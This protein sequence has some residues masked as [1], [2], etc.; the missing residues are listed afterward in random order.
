MIGGDAVE[1]D[2]DEEQ[3]D[4]MQE[5]GVEVEPA[6]DQDMEEEFDIDEQD[7][8]E[9][10]E[11]E[12]EA[13]GVD[14]EEEEGQDEENLEQVVEDC[15]DPDAEICQTDAWSVIS[16]YFIEKG[17]VLQQLE[18]FNEFI[19]NKIQEI[20]E[21]N[22]E[23]NITPES[24]KNPGEED[25]HE[26]M[27]YR[28]KFKQIY[29]SKPSIHEVD[30]EQIAL[31]P[32]E[33]R[34]RNLT[35]AAQL[36]V[37]IEKKQV[38]RTID[39]EYELNKEL[40]PQMVFGKVPIM[41]R[42]TFCSLHGHDDK[43]LAQLGECPYDQGGYFVINGSEKVIIAQERMAHNHVYV[44]KRKQP[45]KYAFTVE[46]KSVLEN[47]TRNATGFM[48]AMYSK[49]GVRSGTGGVIRVQLPYIKS[50]IPIMI[51][52]R[53]LGYV[54]TCLHVETRDYDSL[55]GSWKQLVRFLQIYQIR[56]VLMCIRLRQD[57][58]LW[59]IVQLCE[60]L[61]QEML[62]DYNGLRKYITVATCRVIE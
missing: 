40:L 36:C 11:M 42:S 9:E 27:E 30:G 20:V 25:L 6:F 17:L 29:I 59:N 35:Y 58:Y 52:F 37:D 47:S 26:K 55:S 22:G 39:S 45:H 19:S 10:E 28:V 24:Q 34:L 46:C 13:D 54:E 2:I 41:L 5:D 56:T 43:E 16:A 3:L 33:A 23:M 61:F 50:E 31:F 49:G 14:E 8:H 21:E 44:F 15:D 18:S 32:K 4:E 60:D 53:A 57:M 38:Q 48:I 62:S 7:H 12:I 1:S 51:L